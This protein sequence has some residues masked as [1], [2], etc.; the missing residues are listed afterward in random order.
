MEEGTK[1]VTYFRANVVPFPDVINS[2]IKTKEFLD[3]SKNVVGL[4][5]K[6]FFIDK[7]YNTK[8]FPF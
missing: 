2:K 3:A 7:T 8:S 4:L 5:G 6:I 1:S